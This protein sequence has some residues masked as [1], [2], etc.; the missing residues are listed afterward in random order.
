MR[1][2]ADLTLQVEVPRDGS[3]PTRCTGR[4]RA[5][6]Q[7][8]TVDFDP[9]PSLGG[10]STR[11]LVRPLAN[12]LHRLGLTVVVAGPQGPLIRIGALAR[13]PRWQRLLTGG[14]RVELLSLRG[15][16]GSVGGPKVFEVALPPAAALPVR[17][18]EDRSLRRRAFTMLR[19]TVRRVSG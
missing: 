9:L 5:D 12:Q 4:V 6:G 2:T 7:V 3:N 13:A 19:Q 1:V 17:H 10:G 15:L 16:V 11:P 8:I 14:L 18:D